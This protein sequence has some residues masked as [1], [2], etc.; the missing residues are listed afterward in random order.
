MESGE[1]LSNFVQIIH[2]ITLWNGRQLSETI[3]GN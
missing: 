3:M 2:K 1:Y